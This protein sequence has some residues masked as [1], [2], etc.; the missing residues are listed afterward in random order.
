MREDSMKNKPDAS[1]MSDIELEAIRN[2]D[3]M[4]DDEIDTSEIPEQTD[5]TDSV[6]GKF[7]DPEPHRAGIGRRAELIDEPRG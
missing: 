1:K 3:A 4:S 7:Y 2:L 6:R 5:W